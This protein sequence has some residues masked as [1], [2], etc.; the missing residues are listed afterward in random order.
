MIIYQGPSAIDGSPIVAIATFE[1][2]NRKTGDMVQVWILCD[3]GHAPVVASKL[4]S[5]RAICGE[6]PHRWHLGGICY[7]NIGQAPGAVWRAYMAGQ[8]PDFDAEAFT[9]QPV[10]FG[11]YGDPAAVPFD[12]WLPVLENCDIDGSTGYTHQAFKPWFDARIM[13]F[14]QVS[15]DTPAQARRAQGMGGKTFR[16]DTGQGPQPGEIECLSD[17]RGVSCADCRLCNGQ[18]QN[19]YI[20]AHGSRIIARTA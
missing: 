8:Y 19:I 14:C 13:M 3:D 1:T 16:V 7:V 9:G 11:A 20:A 2:D 18:E 12:A 15:A 17:S 5:D 4:G 6:C 10:R